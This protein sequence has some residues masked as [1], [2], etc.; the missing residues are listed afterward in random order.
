MNVSGVGGGKHPLC[1]YRLPLSV[2]ER[3]S[4]VAGGQRYIF[5][6]GYDAC[7]IGYGQQGDLQA[8]CRR[9]LH[10]NLPVVERDDLYRS[11]QRV[12]DATLLAGI[13]QVDEVFAVVF[14]ELRQ[15]L[16]RRCYEV[17]VDGASAVYGDARQQKQAK[18]YVSRHIRI[19]F[20]EYS[21]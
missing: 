4:A 11:A 6:N 7:C 2:V 5:Y 17:G 21:K 20:C 12:P 8:R 10:G 16:L 3:E 19:F 18:E 15:E 14:A 1:R 9:E 13:E